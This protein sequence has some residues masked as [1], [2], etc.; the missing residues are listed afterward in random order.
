MSKS[1]NK[2]MEQ[3]FDRVRQLP[4][5]RQAEAVAILDDIAAHEAESIRLSEAQQREVARRLADP[6]PKYV[7]DQEMN[8]LFDRL[9]G[10]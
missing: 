9:T 7:S 8:R 5:D 2:A 6:D 3:A 10:A 4:E 1:L